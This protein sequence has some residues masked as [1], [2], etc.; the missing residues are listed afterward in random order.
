V[1]GCELE[2]AM[3]SRK[4]NLV[5]AAVVSLATVLALPAVGLAQ[6][7]ASAK[8]DEKVVLTPPVPQAGRNAEAGSPWGML[9][10]IVF[11]G[12]VI[13]VALIPAKRGH[14]D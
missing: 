13:T 2:S 11:A 12:L 3:L 9:V 7:G 5:P 6:F 10:G 1:A 8:K 4:M 14:Q